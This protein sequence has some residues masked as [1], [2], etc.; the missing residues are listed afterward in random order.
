MAQQGP[1]SGSS[2][3]VWKELRQE[4]GFSSYIDYQVWSGL[5]P[6]VPLFKV[7]G[8]SIIDVRRTK[9]SK[10][11]TTKH[12]FTEPESRSTATKILEALRRP[13]PDVSLRVVLWWC[14]EMTQDDG[15]IS[16]SNI[17][18]ICGLGLKINPQFFKAMDE[19]S[20]KI[21]YNAR[22]MVHPF[23]PSRS[24]EPT[25]TALGTQIFTV[26]RNYLVH[27]ADPPPILLIVGWDND[28]WDNKNLAPAD[29]NDEASTRMP[30]KIASE[31]PDFPISTFSTRSLTYQN[32]LDDL[33]E[34]V[35]D[36]QISDNE[37][38]CLSIFPMIHLDTLHVLA[39]VRSLRRN[40]ILS[41]ATKHENHDWLQSSRFTLRRHIEDSE[42]CLKNIVRFIK[43]HN[44]SV[45]LA[46]GEYLRIEELWEDAIKE[47]RLVETEA[48]DILQL[49]TSQLS[50]EESKRSITLSN[51]QIEESRRGKGFYTPTSAT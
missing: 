22:P 13:A 51:L 8:C 1:S 50:L 48:R 12:D 30:T 21:F 40:A 35:N 46:R 43:A 23:L 3:E 4:T 14:S 16:N 7:N 39:K 25:Y 36:P 19:R 10:I 42:G 28:S 5:N 18:E 44:G 33:L 15:S 32:V 45:L 34:Q 31:I 37:L 41:N 49:Q 27:Q 38:L 17:G 2:E 9:G 29:I 20:N 24:F 26:A 6:F 47:A 11:E